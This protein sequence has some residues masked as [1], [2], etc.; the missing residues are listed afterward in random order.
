[1]EQPPLMRRRN[2][3]LLLGLAIVSAGAGAMAFLFRPQAGQAPAAAPSAPM[4][5][6]SAQEDLQRGRFV[7]AE[8]RLTEALAAAAPDERWSIAWDL[9]RLLRMEGRTAEAQ[10]HFREHAGNYPDP[11]RALRESLHLDNEPYPIEAMQQALEGA[12]RL[13][14]GDDRL[15]L[16]RATLESRRGRFDEAKRWLE[17]CEQARPG[18]PAV[19][20]AWL[21]WALA[22]GRPGESRR[23]LDRV[24]AG[25]DAPAIA[26]TLRAAFDRAAG[27]DAAER[28][29]LT[30]LI[31][32][33][34]PGAL[35]AMERLAEIATRS[36]RGEETLRWRNRR[37]QW[38][39]AYEEYIQ[40]LKSR[41]PAEKAGELARIAQFLG[42][43]FDAAGWQAL[44]ESRAIPSMTTSGSEK[45]LAE[46]FP[47]LL[48]ARPLAGTEGPD[49][50]PPASPRFE[51]IAESA[52]LRFSHNNG[53]TKHQ[54]TPPVTG[55]GGVAAFDYDNDGWLDIY[56]V[57]SGPFPQ[58]APAGESDR[59]FRNRGDGTFED[60]T[61][62]AGIGK[63]A[64]GYGHGVT[65]ADYDNDGH[66]DLFLTRWRGYRVL[67]N[68]GD[69]TF[70]DVTEWV[71]LGGDRD[72]P[73]S[74]AFGDFDHD[75]DLDLF[76]CHYLRWDE[77]D[78][79]SCSDPDDPTRYKCNPRDFPALPDH[80]F[81]NDGG[82][83]VDVTAEAGI[84]DADGRGL[85]VVTAD[86]DGDGLIDIYV[87]NDQSA[88]ALYRNLG[89][90]R[91]EE[92]ALLNGAGANARGGYQA[93]M[94]V[95]LGDTDR[96]G[97]PD[98]VVTN[99]Y[100]E[101]STLFRNLGG[102]QFADA[103]AP[104]GLAALSRYLLGFGVGLP[105]VNNDGRLDYL[106]VNG[107]VFDG[108]PK[109]PWEMPAQLLVQDAG[110][111]FVDGGAGSGKVF[112]DLRMGRGLAIADLDN[113]G[114]LD[115]VL[116]SQ[117]Q[118]LALLMNRTEGAKKAI[119]IQLEGKASPRDGTGARVEVV[120]GD[121][122]WVG[123]A[124]G[125]GSYQSA[126]D[127]R[128]HFG[129]GDA[130]RI[131]RV[132]VTWPSGR[133][134]AYEGLATGAGYR[135]IEGDPAPRPLQGFPPPAGN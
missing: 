74:A 14:P 25:S 45:T 135:L 121:R 100:N 80:L 98:L 56:A 116:Q 101:S 51:E 18:D 90:M 134:D 120:A 91:F 22:A 4:L 9:I 99:F 118:P 61:D 41:N 109:Y 16:A 43:D 47:D 28:E 115:A 102:G 26:T 77:A 67:R 69:G 64:L 34:D 78:L 42:R 112:S 8:R 113:D 81:R 79:R 39:R 37:Q 38:E 70:A 72:W 84:R 53:D 48:T 104:T 7:D 129:A 127:P 35:W 87:A 86:L 93:G 5:W 24:R 125:G 95:A 29:T 10:R 82:K 65:A 132:E 122:R 94:G 21:D 111:R 3:Q 124:S 19:A 17:K 54:L 57:Q 12:S 71:G 59:L 73:T 50:V 11:A 32:R 130:A 2:L 27:D 30:V 96:D 128:L 20:R 92:T 105:D 63:L 46:L 126:N 75:G 76:V 23:V 119:T 110:G 117:N 89:G 103:S 114:R 36:G 13:S 60:V 83:F 106:A 6:E 123:W 62:R 1:M 107:H 66:V 68:G 40:L 108:R 133:R 131:D 85:G 52:G 15:W 55:S 33:D 44:A 58:G 49:K 97:L 31:E 88:N